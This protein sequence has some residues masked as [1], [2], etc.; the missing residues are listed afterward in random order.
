MKFK[1]AFAKVSEENEIGVSSSKKPCLNIDSANESKKPCFLHNFNLCTEKGDHNTSID[2]NLLERKFDVNFLD[3]FSDRS[4]V[5]DVLCHIHHNSLSNFKR[6]ISQH[7]ECVICKKSSSKRFISIIKENV[8]IFTKYLRLELQHD[9]DL[10]TTAKLYCCSLCYK[11]FNAFC[12]SD[13]GEDLKYQTSQ[14]MCEHVHKFKFDE[15]VSQDNLD[16]YTS[17]QINDIVLESFLKEEPLLLPNIYEQ[18]KQ[19]LLVNIAKF[20]Y[21]ISEN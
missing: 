6:E 20:Q 12:R 19:Y 14:Y 4:N 21:V 13:A 5:N 1:R 15:S 11:N 10:D 16:L 17:E 8:D 3:K 18:F 7:V 2:P 9:T